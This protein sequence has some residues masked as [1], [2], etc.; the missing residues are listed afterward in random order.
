LHGYLSIQLYTVVVLITSKITH[1]NTC[2]L[3]LLFIC[4]FFIYKK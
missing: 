3:L 4:Y 2:N 1:S